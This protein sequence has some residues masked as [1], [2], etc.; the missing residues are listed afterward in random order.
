MIKKVLYC[1]F[2]FVSFSYGEVVKLNKIYLD[3]LPEDYKEVFREFLI[4]NFSFSDKV[5]T[6]KKVNLNIS[7]S[8][9]SYNVCFDFIEKDKVRKISCFTASTGEDLYEKFF[10]TL[11]DFKKSEKSEKN[12]LLYIKTNEIPSGK[13]LR[14]LSEK[15]DILVGYKLFKIGKGNP[16]ISGT[17]SLDTVTLEKEAAKKLL[18]LLL[19]G[20]KIKEILIIR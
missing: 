17:V 6:D 8:G 10:K 20:V 5:E 13:K 11:K 2:I 1:F 12:S 19:K 4:S 7:W 3:N 14:I 15:G 18:N 9:I 16:Y